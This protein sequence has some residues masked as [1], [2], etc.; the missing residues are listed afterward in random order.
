M[1]SNIGADKI[2]NK[3]KL[4][5][6]SENESQEEEKVLLA[7]LKKEFRAEFIN[8]I[9]SIV[10][11]RKLD[12]NDL[13][14]ITNILLEEV[15]KRLLQRKISIIISENVKEFIVNN[16]IDLNYGARQLER[17]IK[18]LIEDRVANEILSGRLKE[19]DIIE[20]YMEDNNIKYKIF[21]K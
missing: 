1:T 3:R 6:S 20:F 11:F 21:T 7:E 8:R 17:K 18:E 19:G 12:N 5:F 16:E 10:V 14:K 2:T 9:D 4:G 13:I 15:S